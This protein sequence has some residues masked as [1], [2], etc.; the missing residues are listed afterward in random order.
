MTAENKGRP[1]EPPSPELKKERD[2]FIQSFF[3]KGAQLTQD[4]VNE[5]ARLRHHIAELERDNAQLMAQVKS[6]DA[7]RELLRKIEGLEK[8][9]DHLLS[10]Y[11]KAE[12]EQSRVVG[13][14]AEIEGELANFANLY[15]ASHQLYSSLGFAA[16]ARR[17]KELLE[18]LMGARMFGVYLASSDGRKLVP[19]VT[20][21]ID[22]PKAIPIR[23]DDGG[24]GEAFTTGTPRIE[25]GDLTHGSME[26]PVALVPIKTEEKVI[27]VLAVF[28]TLEQKPKFLPV[29]FEL[30]KL[31][32]AHAGGALIGARLF[33]EAGQKIPSF[34]SLFDAEM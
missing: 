10:H 21:G 16:T 8:E 28:A 9:K 3:Q 30:F 1:S 18:Q 12:A 31:L 13:E 29:D 15:V 5:N 32:G 7:I 20:D 4:L 17:I 24:L 14:Y 22:H 27:G 2:A 11:R 6:D 33:A 23:P 25:K 26:R 19:I 34:D